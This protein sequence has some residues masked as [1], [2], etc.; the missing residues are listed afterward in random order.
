MSSTSVCLQATTFSFVFFSPSGFHALCISGVMLM[1]L[2][3]LGA[4]LG[5][6]FELLLPLAVCAIVVSFVFSVYLYI[7][8]FWVSSHAL[9]LGGNTGES[10]GS[11]SKEEADGDALCICKLFCCLVED[12]GVTV[13]N[14]LTTRLS[15]SLQ[16]SSITWK[17]SSK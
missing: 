1:L 8:S 2:L 14:Y 17:L 3:G 12:F 16:A 7:R 9:A 10:E 13:G 11:S 4:P 5:Y 15:R 6:L